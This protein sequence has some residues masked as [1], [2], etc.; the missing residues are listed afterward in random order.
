MFSFRRKSAV[1]GQIDFFRVL[2]ELQT[3]IENFLDVVTTCYGYEK[4][5]TDAGAS[6]ALQIIVIGRTNQFILMI[7]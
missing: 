4:H 6:N 3:A 7:F 5:S 2:I 1:L